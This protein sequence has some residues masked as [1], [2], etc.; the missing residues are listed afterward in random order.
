[1]KLFVSTLQRCSEIANLIRVNVSR[2]PQQNR[3]KPDD[4]AS[5]PSFTDYLTN[6]ESSE[7]F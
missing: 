4:C 5:Y 2:L 3:V 1:M 6:N 7:N